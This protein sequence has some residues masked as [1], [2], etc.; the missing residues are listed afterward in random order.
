MIHNKSSSIFWASL[1]SILGKTSG[2]YWLAGA[3]CLL[4]LRLCYGPF[5][6]LGLF[7]DEAY[8]HFWSMHL[9]WGYYSKPPMVAWLIYATTTIFDSHSEWAVRLASPLLYFGTACMVFLSTKR[10]YGI[11]TGYYA[12]AI[13]Y[14]APLVSFNSLFITTDAPLLFFWSVSIW[15]YLWAQDKNTKVTWVFVGLAIGMGMLAKYTMVMWLLGF[16]LLQLW[17][18]QP[19]KQTALYP[20][21]I[22]LCMALMMLL[23]NL[24]WNWQHDFISF[25]HTAEISKLQ[26]EWF[27]PEQFIAFFSGQFLVFGPLAFFVLLRF[28]W[29]KTSWRGANRLLLCLTAPLILGMTLMSLLSKA[30][31]NWAAP[32]YVAASIMVAHVL[33]EAQKFRFLRYLIASNLVIA[34]VFYAYPTI[35]SSLQIEPTTKNT[36]FHRVAGWKALFGAI[37]N[38]IAQ[39][40][41]QVWLSDSRSLL[42]YLHY[43]L[44]DNDDKPEV[45]IVS[46]N[47]DGHVTHQFDLYQ[48]LSQ[49]AYSDYVFISEKERNLTGCFGS[50]DLLA[51]LNQAV[52]PSL[53]RTLYLYKVANFQGYQHCH[54]ANLAILHPIR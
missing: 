52:Y 45:N 30:N 43:Y 47:V 54:L 39:P 4:I 7:F 12:A 40:R 20:F 29:D 37:P 46:F 38:V 26:E 18:K 32:V 48:E 1:P 6:Q 27:H 10:L 19:H 8:Y 50:V 33:V 35:Q 2:Q 36:P 31:V 14:T 16:L 15:L 51:Q 23:P 5:T 9:A 28:T 25:Q 22:V 53:N 41:E 21:L 3:L 42:S 24:L 44:P 34:A 13:F 17:Q 11:R 49:T